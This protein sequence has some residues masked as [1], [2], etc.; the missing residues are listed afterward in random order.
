M[1]L[2][3]LIPAL[4]CLVVV[5]SIPAVGLTADWQVPGDFATIQ[6]AINNPDVAEGDTIKVR[7][8]QH[9]GA[10]VTKK[11]FI[12]GERGAVIN[13]G[14]KPW[15][16]KPFNAGF[17]FRGP[18]AENGSGTEIRH[19]KFEDL[20]FPIFASQWGAVVSDVKI[21][22]CLI[23]NAIQGI[24]MWHADDWDVRHNQIVDLRAYHGGGIGILVGSYSGDD[25][26]DNVV[27]QN[28]IFGTV[29][30]DPGDRGGYN[31]A[32][33]YLCADYRGG[34]PGGFVEGNLVSQNEVELKSDSPDI[35]PVA[36]IELQDTRDN[37][38][39]YSVVENTVKS[40]LIEAMEPKILTVPESLTNP[41]NKI[42]KN[43]YLAD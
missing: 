10:I 4:A 35:V 22:H 13:S 17:L 1:I 12:E 30:V 25:A 5:V 18:K 23:V 14:P 41:V 37:P 16:D 31:G 36:A 38:R 24:T 9:R 27:A 42:V 39:R 43:T 8:G 29:K 3:T 34:K 28:E 7:A 32:G 20:D 26:L 11:V 6:A 15:P 2:R 40:N 19:L 33:I 21:H